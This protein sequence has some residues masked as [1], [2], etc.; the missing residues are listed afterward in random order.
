MIEPCWAL[1]PDGLR[2]LTG[3][4]G[5]LDT[6]TDH[7]ARGG[8]GQGAVAGAPDAFAAAETDVLEDAADADPLAQEL[9]AID[10]V[11]ARTARVLDVFEAVMAV[12]VKGAYLA[13][14]HVV[15]HMRDGGAIV[16]TSSVA[17]MRG[18]AG[19]YAYI[20][21]KHAQVGLMRC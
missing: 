20:I 3:R 9:A 2:A 1:A 13:A 15:P 17:A 18:D 5:L 11:L 12:H 19:V 10:A 4:A 7:G 14:K 8:A 6:D 16:I 21:A